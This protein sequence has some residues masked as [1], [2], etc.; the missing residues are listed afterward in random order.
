VELDHPALV[1]PAVAVVAAVVAAEIPLFY[2]V[3]LLEDVADHEVCKRLLI[4]LA[5]RL[6]GPG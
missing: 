6:M 2:V 1:D 3:A 4:R 5:P